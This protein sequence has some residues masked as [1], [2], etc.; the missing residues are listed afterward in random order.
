MTASAL[1]VRVPEAE[2]WVDAIRQRHDPAAVVGVPAH[3]T[4]LS[5]FLP[6]TRPSTATV[7]AVAAV[8][9]TLPPF[10]F[11]LA[12]SGRWPTV[13]Y[14]AP[15]PA[16]P[17][18]RMTRALATRFPECPPYGGAHAEIVPHLTY[19]YG[20]DLAAAIAAVD[21]RLHAAGPV[22]ARC[23]AIEW[24]VEQPMGLWTCL[25]VFPLGGVPN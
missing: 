2:G 15:T 6:T 8:C 17:F 3:V 24:W 5:P 10:P 9:A 12:A 22:L 19:A 14:L 23:A 13:A 7:T 25:Q 20:E 11:R 18:I 21:A 1:I 16:D 4:V